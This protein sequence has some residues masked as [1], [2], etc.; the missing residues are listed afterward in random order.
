MSLSF[1]EL[2]SPLVANA[3]AAFA[4][5]FVIIA[6]VFGLVVVAVLA[7]RDRNG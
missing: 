5:G 1:A 4:T 2:P 3:L 7:E 6:F